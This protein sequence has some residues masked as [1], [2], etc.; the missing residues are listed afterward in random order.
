MR[1]APDYLYPDELD[2]GQMHALARGLKSRHN[3]CIEMF[4]CDTKI[5][6]NFVKKNV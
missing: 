5:T 6:V 4:D 1:R 2:S 3:P